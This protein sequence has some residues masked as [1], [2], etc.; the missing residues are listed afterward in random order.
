MRAQ[1]TRVVECFRRYM[2]HGGTSASR[3]EFESNLEPKLRD[4]AF[5]TVGSTD[6]SA[7]P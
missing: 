5:E 1:P 3:A 4:P 7:R 2:D 6:P